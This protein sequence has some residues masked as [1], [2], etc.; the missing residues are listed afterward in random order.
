M[1]FDIYSN[2]RETGVLIPID[3]CEITWVTVQHCWYSK[4]FSPI[5]NT[6]QKIHNVKLQ[7]QNPKKRL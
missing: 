6:N 5:L 7:L 1:E 3:I 4:L 2:I